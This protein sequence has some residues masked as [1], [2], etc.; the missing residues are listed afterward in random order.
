MLALFSIGSTE[1]SDVIAYIPSTIGHQWAM[2]ITI[3]TGMFVMAF[4]NAKGILLEKEC[5]FC[6]TLRLVVFT[7]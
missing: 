2:M 5:Q 6:K 3:L 4:I 1:G 7:Q